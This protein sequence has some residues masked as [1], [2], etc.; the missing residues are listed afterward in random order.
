MLSEFS[1][2]GERCKLTVLVVGHIIL[3]LR[4][5]GLERGITAVG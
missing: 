2:V 5:G 4:S 1:P 3:N